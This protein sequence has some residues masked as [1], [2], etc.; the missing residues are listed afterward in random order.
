MNST[1]NSP[2]IKDLDDSSEERRLEVLVDSLGDDFMTT[3]AKPDVTEI[4]VNDDGEAARPECQPFFQLDA[5]SGHE[6]HLLGRGF[7]ERNRF[8]RELQAGVRIPPGWFAFFRAGAARG[9]GSMLQP[10]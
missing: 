8:F 10:A 7:C 4:N 3:W 1:L 6:R 9:P 5:I 2:G